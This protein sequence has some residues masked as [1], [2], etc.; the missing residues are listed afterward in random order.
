MASHHQRRLRFIHVIVV[1]VVVLLPLVLGAPN[2]QVVYKV[3]GAEDP[4]PVS[5]YQDYARHVRRDL[6][7]NTATRG[8][9]YYS[10]IEKQVK[11]Y[12]HAACRRRIMM[13]SQDCIACLQAAEV[14]WLQG[15]TF[16]QHFSGIIK[17]VDCKMRWAPDPV[18]DLY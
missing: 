4:N 3:Y 1:A 5:E 10:R 18:D 12:G 15:Q 17:L 8:F 13:S 16:E 9:D 11:C 2:T 14:H 6:I 7:Q